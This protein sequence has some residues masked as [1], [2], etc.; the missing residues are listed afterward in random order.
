M[1]TKDLSE[2]F[3]ELPENLRS[4]ESFNTALT[5]KSYF[6]ENK[7]EATAHNERLE[8]LGDAALGLAVA[9][10]LFDRFPDRDE[11]FLTKARANLVNTRTLSEKAV[12][13]NLSAQIRVGKSEQRIE[14]SNDP[15]FSNRILASTLEALLGAIYLELGL[16]KLYSFIECLFEKEFLSEEGLLQSDFDW[17]SKLQEHFQ[18]DHQKTPTYELVSTEGP[19]HQKTF[20]STVSFNDEALAQGVG[21]SRKE[22]EQDAAKKAYLSQIGE[23][24]S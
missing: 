7:N 1:K 12:A 2:L 8:F 19:D 20:Y 5:H 9:R 15:V 16:D 14:G 18:K 4:S 17:K 21:M 10:L 3:L 11:G 24:E 22:A 13:L 6:F 23:K